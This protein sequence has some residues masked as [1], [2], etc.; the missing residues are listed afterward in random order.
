MIDILSFAFSYRHS[1]TIGSKFYNAVRIVVLQNHYV[2]M[3]STAQLALPSAM[4]AEDHPI[5]LVQLQ[6]AGRI[7]KRQKAEVSITNKMC[8]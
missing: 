6:R 7:W 4:A 1:Q 5:V 8:M 3:C 2:D